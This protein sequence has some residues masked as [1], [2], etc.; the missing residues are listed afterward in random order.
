MDMAH[1][2]HALGQRVEITLRPFD[3]IR[4]ERPVVVDCN[5]ARIRVGFESVI[6]IPFHV[7]AS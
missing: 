6:A 4:A 7:F 2:Q 3:D 1:G 5:R